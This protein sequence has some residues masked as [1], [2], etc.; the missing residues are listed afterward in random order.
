MRYHLITSL[1][2][3]VR[4]QPDDQMEV[5]LIRIRLPFLPHVVAGGFAEVQTANGYLRNPFTAQLHPESGP[6]LA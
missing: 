1:V 5:S 4:V 3:G 6:I 2:R